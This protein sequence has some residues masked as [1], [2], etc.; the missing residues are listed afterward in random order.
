MITVRFTDDIENI[1]ATEHLYQ[2]DIAKIL[3]IK[4]LNVGSPKVHFT[5][6]GDKT[7]LVVQS[8][9]VN[10]DIKAVI[11]DK[12]LQSGKAVTAY[13]Y[14]EAGVSKYTIKTITIP[15]IARVKPND[16]VETN[17]QDV[18]VTQSY[19]E[20]MNERVNT[21]END[22]DNLRDEVDRCGQI[23]SGIKKV[24]SDGNMSLTNS[25]SGGIK[26]LKVYGKSEQGENPSPENIQPIVSAGQM[27]TLGN[28]LFDKST[29]EDRK[30]VSVNNGVLYDDT[31]V[32]TSDFINIQDCVN[33]AW[34]YG[35]KFG[36]FYN[37][38]KEFIS[39]FSN[40]TYVSIPTNATY[41]R[42]TLGMGEKEEFMLNK[43]TVAL[44]WEPYT[45]GVKKAYD[46]GI[47]K[48]LTGK[49]QWDASKDTVG[50]HNAWGGTWSL[51]NQTYTCVAQSTMIQLFSE[52]GNHLSSH[53]KSVKP[54]DN[55]TISTPGLDGTQCIVLMYDKYGN[56]I[57][58]TGLQNTPWSI[59]IPSEVYFIG[60]RID[61]YQAVVDKAYRFNIQ[62]EYGSEATEYEPYTEQT[63]T[64]NR[65]LRGIPVTDASLANYTDENG[66]MWCADYGDVERKVWVQRIGVINSSE[67][68]TKGGAD[69]KN[70][71]H[72]YVYDVPDVYKLADVPV[73]CTHYTQK[74]EF[75]YWVEGD[76]ISSKESTKGMIYI[77]STT[78]ATLEEFKVGTEGMEI[79]YILATPIETP[80]TDEEIIALSSLKSCDRVTYISSDNVPDAP[81]EVEYGTSKAGA[82]ALENSNLHVVNEVLRVKADNAIDELNS[83]LPFKIEID[84]NARTINFVDR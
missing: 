68:V 59:A 30:G 36:A 65:V 51:D 13:I 69:A 31:S 72:N 12:V 25:H 75:V 46:V 39:A 17:T 58:H 1:T 64:L 4:G 55:I 44:P 19:F 53:K 3:N 42:I 9:L 63:L 50:S 38:A 16:Y 37:N 49:N 76:Y 74:P 22:V 41:L 40:N 57:G 48:K 28:Q 5:T 73:L 34:N 24:S 62:L 29:C 32:C 71:G 8:E 56:Y 21:L 15:V 70:N 60:I 66:Q 33:I 23:A 78:F 35:N 6:K 52:S 20:V 47:R 11:P 45:G 43:G 2:W 79:Q 84:D 77:A 67:S 61:Y 82:L 83:A 81:M 26:I 10:G 54:N 14:L 80:L 18:T 27:L 7:A